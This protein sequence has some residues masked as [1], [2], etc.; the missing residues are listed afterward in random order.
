ML[1]KKLKQKLIYLVINIISNRRIV[2]KLCGKK[3][4]KRTKGCRIK[5][6]RTSNLDRDAAYKG[7]FCSPECSNLYI[8]QSL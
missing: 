4:K 7:F 5:F 8:L 1:K 3:C 6:V 2:C